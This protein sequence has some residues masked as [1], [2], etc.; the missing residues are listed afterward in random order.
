MICDKLK[1]V[2][3]QFKVKDFYVICSIDIDQQDYRYIQVLKVWDLL[4]LADI[5]KLVKSLDSMFLTYTDD[6]LNRC[7][8]KCVEG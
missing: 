2:L 8:E 7:Q 3:K 6:F 4:W 1:H 5:P